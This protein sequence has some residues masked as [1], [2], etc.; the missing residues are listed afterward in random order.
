MV[1]VAL[2][3]WRVGTSELADVQVEARHIDQKLFDE[4]VLAK[5]GAMWGDGQLNEEGYEVDD[6]FEDRDDDEVKLGLPSEI[7]AFEQFWV[8]CQDW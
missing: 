1:V 8:M 6:L 7:M 3:V 5:L 2:A 4:G